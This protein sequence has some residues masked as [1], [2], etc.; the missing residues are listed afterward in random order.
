[1]TDGAEIDRNEWDAAFGEMEVRD[2][3]AAPEADLNLWFGTEFG[4]TRSATISRIPSQYR[5][6]LF[7][8]CDIC[9][10]YRSSMSRDDS[11]RAANLSVDFERVQ[12]L[13]CGIWIREKCFQQLPM[14][15]NPSPIPW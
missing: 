1:M 6:R 14:S 5:E 13:A 4:D 2:F 3:S 9:P 11:I 15:T 12:H 7:F 8:Q 10:A